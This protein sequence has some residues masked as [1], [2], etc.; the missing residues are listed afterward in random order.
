MTRD[1]VAAAG[2][3]STRAAPA[4]IDAVRV[5]NYDH[6]G[7]HS[8]RVT[9]EGPEGEGHIGERCYLAPGQSRVVEGALAPGEYRVT[10]R[11]DGVDRDGARCRLEHGPERTALVEL[12]NGVVSVTE[13]PDRLAPA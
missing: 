12:G 4:A 2:R 9:V 7:G 8:V 13:G 5:R 6:A 1:A 11:V 10:V 3:P